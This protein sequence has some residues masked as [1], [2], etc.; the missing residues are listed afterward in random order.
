MKENASFFI[1]YHSAYTQLNQQKTR[2]NKMVMLLLSAKQRNVFLCV[3]NVNTEPTPLVESFQLRHAGL[4][5][6]YCSNVFFN[7]FCKGAIL[8]AFSACLIINFMHV[9]YVNYIDHHHIQ[10]L[11]C[12]VAVMWGKYNVIV[13]LL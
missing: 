5:T 9:T 6:F 13:V 11:A 3:K 10:S 8:Y 4:Y 1:L 12:V 7:W 2:A